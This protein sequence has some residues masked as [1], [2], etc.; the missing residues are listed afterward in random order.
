MPTVVVLA[1]QVRDRACVNMTVNRKL[2]CAQDNKKY[3]RAGFTPALLFN[4]L[5]FFLLIVFIVLEN[6]KRIE[7]TEERNCMV[8]HIFE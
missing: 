6:Q 1:A 8:S 5:T 4:I 2:L 7:T 3:K